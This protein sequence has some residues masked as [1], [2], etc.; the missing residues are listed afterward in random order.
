MK[1]LYHGGPIITMERPGYAEA[2]LT[3]DERIL[4]VGSLEE[5]LPISAGAERIDLKGRALLPGFIDAHSH[6]TQMANSMLQ[7]S[8][9]GAGDTDEIARRVSAFIKNSGLEPGAWVIA[10]DYDNNLF[11]G[12]RD[13][14]LFEIDRLCP[15]YKLLI[16]H[17]SGH[18]G[19]F[20]S[21]AMEALGLGPDTEDIEGGYIG[22]QDG[23]LTGYLE[24]N[25]FFTYLKK[26]PSTELKTLL[27][28]YGRAQEI[29]ASNGIT[30]I[31]EGMLV[32]E[33]LP[34]YKALL[35]SGIL[36]LDLIAY[37]SPEAYAQ[38][39][40]SLDKA[41]NAH[42]KTGGIKVFL[43]GSPQGRTAWMRTPYLGSEDGYRG[44]GT[45]SD[46]ELISAFRLA[47]AEKT[48]LIAHC[49]GDAASEQFLRCLMLVEAEQPILKELRP[50]IIHGQLMGLDQLGPAAELGAMVSFFVAHV[51]HWGDTHVKNFGLR[52]A[53]EISPC[54]S[55]KRAGLPF[56]LHQDSPV[57]APDMLET[58][59]CASERLSSG[60]TLLGAE[61]R[62]SVID[63]LRAVTKTAAEQYGL[64]GLKGSLAPGK[65]ADLVILSE[66]PAAAPKDMLRQI[67]VEATIKAGKTVYGNI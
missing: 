23:R 38:A 54:A 5:L 48:Q 24:E 45:M 57:I 67:S 4:A 9:D 22:R 51:Y 11:P 25:A 44:Y 7:L 16:H 30:T 40:S 15:G 53:A 66:D 62:I 61:E 55:A 6:F 35:A 13:P 12:A 52:R 10:R 8:L 34:M 47:A 58:I 17:K 46:E 65:L 56:T 31:Q 32:G 2:V 60:G 27:E 50:L 36:E 37:A 39:K 33:M 3:L 59:W 49:N 28:A 19:L 63:A 64:G 20:N 41:G 14:E 1:T 21:L 18:M 42:Y 43:D 29:Y 26:L